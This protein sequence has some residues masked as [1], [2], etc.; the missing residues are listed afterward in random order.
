MRCNA[1]TPNVRRIR[2]RLR[3]DRPLIHPTQASTARA[4][5][6]VRSV[7]G[8]P[9]LTTAVA[10]FEDVGL[11]FAPEELHRLD[12]VGTLKLNTCFSAEGFRFADGSFTGFN[13]AD[14]ARDG[15]QIGGTQVAHSDPGALRNTCR[16]S[17]TNGQ[18][19]KQPIATE[20]TV[21]KYSI[22]D[23]VFTPTAAP[24]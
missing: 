20:R 17:T 7:A 8:G 9:T 19:V 14:F 1:P 10:G 18:S 4:L 5:N 13:L 6:D 15:Q 12:T 22:I 11:E 3:L 16:L 24:E 23:P 21:L 2:P